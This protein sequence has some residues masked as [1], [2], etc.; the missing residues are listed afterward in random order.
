MSVTSSALL[1]LLTALASA[2]LRAQSAVVSGT[3]HVESGGPLR[4][5]QVAVMGSNLGTLTDSGGHYRLAPVSPGV[6][7][8]SARFIGYLPAFDTVS[9]AP[10]DSVEASFVLHPSVIDGLPLVVVGP[11][12]V[13]AAK[14]SQ[15]LDQAVTS[16]AVVSDTELARRAVSTVDEAVDKA[17]GVQFLNGQVNIRGST[18]YVQGLG[19][20]VLLLVDGVPANQGDR[21]GI[22]WDVVPLDRVERVEVVKGAGSSLYGSAALGGVVNLITREIPLGFHARVRA[23]GS[24]FS[25]PPHD[26]WRFRGYNRAREGIDV[27]ASYGTDMFRGSYSTGGWHS[28]GYREQDRQDHW[29]TGGKVE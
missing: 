14:R 5:A 18:G 22:N 28:D 27:T 26:I 17:P 15:L 11:V 1:A 4:F 13:T 21:G 2:E 12:V 7:I 24:L 6:V 8:V 29:Q 3:V 16:V 23:T 19:S 25:N 9:V 10:G 20:R